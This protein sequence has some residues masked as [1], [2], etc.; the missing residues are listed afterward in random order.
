MDTKSTKSTDA[1]AKKKAEARAAIILGI[2][3]GGI[4]LLA[5]AGMLAFDIYAE[6]HTGATYQAPADAADR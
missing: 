5:I 2:I 3:V 6:K 1:E 4:I